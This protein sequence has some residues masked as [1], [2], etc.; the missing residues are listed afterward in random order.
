MRFKTVFFALTLSAPIVVPAEPYTDGRLT[1]EIQVEMEKNRMSYPTLGQLNDSL[2]SLAQRHPSVC[3]L[4]SIGRSY[5]NRTIYCLEI[6]D[7]PGQDEG[8]PELLFVGLHHANEWSSCAVPLFYCDS[9]LRAYGTD[10]IVTRLVDER[11]FWFIPCFNV[12]G[13]YYSRDLNHT[14][15]RKNRRPWGG[16]IGID[17]NR[18]Y[19]GA[20]TGNALNTWGGLPAPDMASHDPASEFF[21]GP[22]ALSESENQAMYNFLATRTFRTLVSYHN[23]GEYVL[24]PWAWSITPA[25]DGSVIQ[26]I[27]N[28]LANM[29]IKQS[30]SG[31]YTGMQQGTWYRLCSEA[32]DFSYGYARYTK[33]DPCLPFGVEL[34]QSLAPDTVILA[35]IS[36]QNIKAL[37]HLARVIDTVI[38]LTPR[39][40]VAPRITAVQNGP[41][42]DVCWSPKTAGLADGWRLWEMMKESAIQD[43]FGAS[44]PR[45]TMSGFT[46][47]G[48][49]AHSGAYCLVSNY[50]DAAIT[51]AGTEYPY[52]VS[53]ADTAS[54]WVKYDLELNRDVLFFE[55]SRDGLVWRQY[56]RFTGTDTIWHRVQVPLTEYADQSVF[57]RF[58]LCTDG[59]R[60][61]G[62]FIDDFY[63]A[64][65][66]DSIVT[67][68]SLPDTFHHF[69]KTAAGA[70]YYRTVGYNAEGTGIFS[71]LI[72]VNVTLGVSE[73]KTDI[74]RPRLPTVVRKFKPAKGMRL[75]NILGQ[76]VPCAD[77]PGIYFLRSATGT[78]K[79]IVVK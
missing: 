32:K 20:S 68:T 64:V 3:R 49:G 44:N 23:Y 36:R 67:Y 53:A 30:G 31:H 15:W 10:T 60:Y 52:L 66:Y 45:W 16:S 79:I 6:S 50:A 14:A 63:P 71:P 73:E 37:F 5:E 39:I 11:R 4:D 22:Y 24:W 38:A 43:T 13:Y 9:L 46:P 70:Y 19:P 75:F 7:N 1:P 62:V 51:W 2:R 47:G 33:G 59:D 57:F 29:I 34:G 21:C 54:F 8:E 42:Y 17:L 18:N 58:R 12:D 65:A 35:Q 77:Q 48:Q 72:R 41:Q 25:P 26:A 27:G 78:A 69:D 55:I 28:E 76:E 61:L 40:V 56:G 74:V